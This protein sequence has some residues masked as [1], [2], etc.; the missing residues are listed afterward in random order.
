MSIMTTRPVLD[1]LIRFV[2]ATLE[3]ASIATLIGVFI[4]EAGWRGRGVFQEAF[5][6]LVY[7]M[8]STFSI[9]TIW[10]GVSRDNVHAVK[11]Y[12]R[13]GFRDAQPPANLFANPW[14]KSR[15]L[16]YRHKPSG[17]E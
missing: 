3:L 9:S 14:P 7:Y 12:E 2:P 13:N 11:A 6:A 17:P 5:S 15:Y 1:D 8:Q 16:V 10:L 4:G